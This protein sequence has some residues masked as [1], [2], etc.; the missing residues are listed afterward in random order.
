MNRPETLD[1][2]DQPVC[3]GTFKAAFRTHAG[4]VAVV[5]ADNGSGPAALTATSVCSVSV[6]PNLLLF[7][8]ADSSSA[9]PVLT[10]AASVVVHL[11]DAGDLELARLGATSGVD[12][13]QD[14]SLWSTLATG[15]PRYHGV[16]TWIRG[17]V[18]NRVAAGTS[19]V[20]LVEATRVSL[21]DD[22]RT[23]APLVH[24]DRAWHRLGDDSRL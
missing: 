1:H 19:T 10:T 23:V 18:V 14:T 20:I 16:R 17:V 24:H 21:P 5:T 22:G 9:A 15:E 7:S 6:D 8:V 12:R 2:T 3:S 4:G 11:L 13:F